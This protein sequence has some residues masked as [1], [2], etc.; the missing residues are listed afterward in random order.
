[1]GYEEPSQSFG[2]AKGTFPEQGGHRVE[3]GGL[4]ASVCRLFSQLQRSSLSIQLNIAEG[5]AFGDS[6]TLRKHVRIAY[7][8]A[9]E[10]DDLLTLMS[11]YD[12]FD[13]GNMTR[14]LQIC[15]EAQKLLF[16]LMKRYGALNEAQKTKR[17]QS[18]LA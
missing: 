16:G 4:E 5:Y 14:V 3:Y 6:A 2:L 15:D 8:S 17:G 1:V 13:R 18:R 12:H 10:S 11:E 9:V 7:G